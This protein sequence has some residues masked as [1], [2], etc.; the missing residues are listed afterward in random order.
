[1]S[2]T[3]KLFAGAAIAAAALLGAS[4]ASALVN[5]NIQISVDENGNGTIDGFGGLATLASALQN[6]PGPGGLNNVLTYDMD[7]PPGLVEGDVYLQEGIGGPIFD[8]IR[9][10]P[11]EV[12]P[13]GGL[14]SLLF[15]SDNVDGFDSLADTF[16]PPG[17]SY[18]NT[19]TILEVGPE[20]NNGATY[21][22]TAGQ[23]GFVAGASAPVTY[24]FVSDGTLG[25][26]EPATWGLMLLGIGGLGVA[27]R[28]R[29]RSVLA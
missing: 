19:V 27:L 5:G 12:G 26:P 13:G 15:Y 1:M 7:N 6:D 21:T 4:S 25:V 8:V 11:G 20:G 16:G 3:S 29:S 2:G 9:F 28:S 18:A 14:G 17:A 24:V 22:P 23:P 10:N